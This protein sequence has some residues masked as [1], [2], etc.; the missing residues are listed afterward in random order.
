MPAEKVMA[1]AHGSRHGPSCK[2]QA[3]PSPDRG[4]E[5]LPF[6]WRWPQMSQQRATANICSTALN[7]HGASDGEMQ[8]PVRN[9]GMIRAGHSFRAMAG[10]GLVKILQ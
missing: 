6:R 4:K 3:P 5:E 8:I 10:L 1:L 2:T 9:M 7:P